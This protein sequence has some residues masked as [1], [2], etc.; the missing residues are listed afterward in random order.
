MISCP[1]CAERLAMQGHPWVEYGK[2]LQAGWC[3]NPDCPSYGKPIKF[4]IMEEREGR[5]YES[6]YDIRRK[7]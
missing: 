1:Y 2:W 5:N 4:E 6:I 7:N 3:Y